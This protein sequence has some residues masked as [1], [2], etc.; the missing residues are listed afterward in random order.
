VNVV[1]ANKKDGG[2]P[3]NRR[4][5]KGKGVEGEGDNMIRVK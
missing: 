2:R 1:S 5:G 3:N 4:D